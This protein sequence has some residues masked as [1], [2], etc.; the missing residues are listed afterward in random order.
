MN[1]L[2]RAIKRFGP[3]APEASLSSSSARPGDRRGAGRTTAASRSS[4]P[5]AR[6]AWARSSGPRSPR[7]SAARILE[8]GGNNAMIVA[9][10]ADLDL[11]IRARSSSPPSAP[12]AS[13]APRSAASSSTGRSAPSSP[14]GW[15]R[16][17]RSLPIGD[18]RKDGDAGRPADRP[19]RASTRCRRRSSAPRP[20]AASRPWRR[21][22]RR[23]RAE[24]R[25]LSSSRRSSRC[26]RRRR[27]C[28]RRPSRRS[29]T[30]S[31]YD[32][33]DEAIAIHNDVPQ[34]LSSSIFTLNMREAETFLSAAGTDCGI[35]NV[36]I[37]TS[38]A[39]IGGAFGGEKETGGGRE[40]RLRRLEGLHAP[41]DQHGQLF[42]QAAA[43]AGRPVRLL[44]PRWDSAPEMERPTPAPISRCGRTEAIAG[45]APLRNAR[46]C[47]R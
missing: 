19:R 10:S 46:R 21:N 39:E 15:S 16:P 28:A 44:A 6:P 35:A 47:P 13:A 43:G 20:R 11:A 4:P 22:G 40:S 38:G 36:N 26:R 31:S 32:D 30:C 7:A 37:G 8:L 5:P 2:D 34:G 24:R 1:I 9:P 41:A 23:R 18:P 12:P 3:D 27:S 29:S 25:R 17:T 14:T 42:G 33:L 45:C